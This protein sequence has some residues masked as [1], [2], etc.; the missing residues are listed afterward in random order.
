M[1]RGTAGQPAPG[2]DGPVAE[3]SATATVA[4]A[5]ALVNGEPV[6][7]EEY[8]RI[9]MSTQS[10]YVEKGLDPNT[11]EGQEQLRAIRRA[12]LDDLIDQKLI[13]QA[14]SELGI[15]VT[16]QEVQESLQ[17]TIAAAGGEAEFLQSL[18]DEDMGM[19]EALAMERASLLGRRLFEHVIPA[20]PTAAKF[21]HARHIQCESREACQEAASRLQAGEAFDAVARQLSADAL[22][23]DQG[24]DL[25]WVGQG[26]LPSRLAEEAIFA[27]AAGERSD[28]VATEYGYHIFEVLEWDPERSIDEEQRLSIWEAEMLRWLADRRSQAVIEILIEEL[29]ATPAPA[30]S[31]AATAVPASPRP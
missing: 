29:R 27:L 24:G 7:L 15:V 11:A 12:I 6:P 2:T 8:R 30:E 19:E 5:A 16:E 3:V 31:E 18:A 28:I 26:T 13:E 17:R 10:Y 14:A 23:R 21:A 22:T 20:V 25:G 1:A 9:A 4:D